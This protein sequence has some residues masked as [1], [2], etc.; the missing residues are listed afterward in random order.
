M[1]TANTVF[2][3]LINDFIAHFEQ[4]NEALA[5]QALV[6]RL[7]E[8]NTSYTVAQLIT[9]R[10]TLQARQNTVQACRTAQ[11]IARGQ[12][13]LQKAALLTQFNLFTALLDGYF[14]NTDFYEAR[15]LAPSLSDGQENF[16]RPLVDAMVLWEE[17]NEGPAPAGVVL[18]LKLGDATMHGAFA[19]A[20]SA[21]QFAYATEQRKSR[22][23]VLARAR[24][25]RVQNTAYEAMKSYRE[26]VPGMLSNFPE[27]IETLP[28]L[29]PLPGHTPEAVNASAV[30]VAP[31]ESRVVYD[32]ST[33]V[34]LHSYQLRGSAGD[35]YDDEDAVVIATNAPGAPR[36]FVTAFGLN[37]PGAQ[38]ALKV[39]VLLTT[40]NEAG[41]AAMV[42]ERPVSVPLAA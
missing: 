20:V 34:M 1:S 41:S 15:P 18:P 26:A 7:P 21:L 2:I 4:S 32:A 42:V 27:L 37:Q 5:P 29:S 39:Y 8:T 19:S 38:I 16:T 33:D 36:E 17:I 22:G 6:I 31:N 13:N 10:D 24:R 25:N 12:I 35:D 11:Q 30:F 23:L 40:G 9:L 14:R 3:P 28:R